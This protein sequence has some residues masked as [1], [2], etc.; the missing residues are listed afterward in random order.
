M[1]AKPIQYAF[2]ALFFFSSLI[3][4]GGLDSLLKDM[5]ERGFIVEIGDISPDFSMEYLDGSIKNLSDY[6]GQIVML[7]FTASWCSVCRKEMPHIEN[8]VWQAFKDKD[9]VVI[10]I[11]RDEPKDVVEKFSE[12]MNITY[13]LVLDP[14]AEIFG[15][16]AGK[17]SG[18]TR[19]IILDREGKIVFLTRLFDQA[20]FNAMVKMIGELIELS[21]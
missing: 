8:E 19:N 4:P 5:D 10:G 21:H 18:V 20:E 2:I 13:P 1:R 12:E 3:I 6:R 11:D 15:L 16:F 17:E 7:Q 14:G 9:L